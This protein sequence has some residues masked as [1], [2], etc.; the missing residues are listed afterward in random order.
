MGTSETSTVQDGDLVTR[1][2]EEGEIAADYLEEFLD[3]A[4]LDGDIDI[5]VEHGRAAVEIVAEDVADDSLRRL[6]G[7]DG[8][9]LDALQ[10]L[11]RLAVQTK[12]GERSRLMLDIAGYRAER[13]TALVEVARVAIERVKADGTPVTLDPMNPFERKVVHDAVAEAGLVSDSEGVE[14]ERRVVIHP[15]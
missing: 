12:T 15:A 13:R 3:I 5:D 1:L 11:T 14:P 9:V 4:D 8:E 7:K 2:E 10:E 6:V